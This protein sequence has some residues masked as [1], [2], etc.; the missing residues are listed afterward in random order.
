MLLEK[1]F[2]GK[3]QLSLGHTL[4]EIRAL[5]RDP[6]VD[7]KVRRNALLMFGLLLFLIANKLLFLSG[8]F[9]RL[10]PG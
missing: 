6:H 2:T 8:L 7:L 9:A 1:R 3:F 10:V 4:H 5:Q